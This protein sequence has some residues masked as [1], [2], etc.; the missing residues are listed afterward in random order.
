MM[1]LQST[2]VAPLSCVTLV[3]AALA[4][5]ASGA[6]AQS[7]VES[8]TTE[9]S[10]GSGVLQSNGGGPLF[11]DGAVVFTGFDGRGYLR[12]AQNYKDISF[13]AE[14]TVTVASGSGGDGIAF[15]G[16]GD[17][18]P[19]FFYGEPYTF[20]SIY[21]RVMPSDFYSQ[22]SVT[23]GGTEHQALTELGG[24]GAYRVRITWNHATQMFTSAFQKDYAGGTFVPTYTSDPMPLNGAGLLTDANARIFFGG[25]GNATFDDLVI[26]ALDCTTNTPRGLSGQF[27]SL[28]SAARALRFS[29]EKGLMGAVVSACRRQ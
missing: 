15:F 29:G 23:N 3:V 18:E 13:I 14:V 12:T 26:L 25:A 17:G 6:S 10:V 5:S 1:T 16:M 2:R 4:A 20:S 22:I 11:D 9:L 28:A 8:F 19:T 7:L 21:T 27:R 24:D